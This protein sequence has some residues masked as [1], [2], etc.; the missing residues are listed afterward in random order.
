MA[1]DID[2]DPCGGGDRAA[3]RLEAVFDVEGADELV[4]YYQEWSSEYENDLLV[5][6]GYVYHE[7]VVDAFG[8]A[9]SRGDGPVLDVG[10]GT[11]MVGAALCRVG[12]WAIDGL[13]LS[14][15]MLAEAGQKLN[16]AGEPVYGSLIEADLTRPLDINT[17]TY[18]AVIT[19]GTFTTGHVGPEAIHELIRIV[20]PA[21]LL[22]LGVASVHYSE[23]GFDRFIASLVHDGQITEP[24]IEVKPVYARSGPHE[25]A[26]DTARIVVARVR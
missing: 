8:A 26:A 17:D 2:D 13:D 1:A 5:G 20:R 3:E 14:P 11:G 4:R 22:V 18:G 10:C 19:A 6:L 7:H 9:A 24:T 25:H 15:E 16:S 23:R 21:G 12:W